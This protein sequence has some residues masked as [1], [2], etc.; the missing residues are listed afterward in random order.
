MKGEQPHEQGSWFS[1]HVSMLFKCSV[2]AVWCL[3]HSLGVSR[4]CLRCVGLIAYV[5]VQRALQG[6]LHERTVGSIAAPA[7]LDSFTDGL[8]GDEQRVSSILHPFILLQILSIPGPCRLAESYTCCVRMG[9]RSPESRRESQSSRQKCHWRRL[10]LV[11]TVLKVIIVI[12]VVIVIRVTSIAR[13]VGV[14]ELSSRVRCRMLCRE[15]R[16][17]AKQSMHGNLWL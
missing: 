8:E 13:L 12:I 14:I 7:I 5:L 6:G 11:C 2:I 15:H 17:R 10:Q 3:F 9:T 16:S 4:F 1:S